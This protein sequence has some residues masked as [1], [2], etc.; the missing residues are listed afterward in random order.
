MILRR[1]PLRCSTWGGTCLW[2]IFYG[3][4]ILSLNSFQDVFCFQNLDH[5]CGTTTL[6][7]SIFFCGTPPKECFYRPLFPFV[8]L[9]LCICVCDTIKKVTYKLRRAKSYK[10]IRLF[11]FL[12]K[13]FTIVMEYRPSSKYVLLKCIE[14]GFNNS[15]SLMIYYFLA[16]FDNM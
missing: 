5:E 1:D 11:Q 9:L 7:N 3:N 4:F 16:S 8:L 2:Y 13:H 15:H 10:D 6:R 14:N 12:L